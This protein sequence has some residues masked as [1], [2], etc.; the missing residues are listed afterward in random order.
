MI[1]NFTRPIRSSGKCA[2][3]TCKA[4]PSALIYNFSSS[5]TMSQGKVQYNGPNT[6]P[7]LFF[8]DDHMDSSIWNHLPLVDSDIFINSSIKSGTTWTQEIVLQLLYHGDYS[9]VGHAQM[10]VSLWAAGTLLTNP[11]KMELMEAQR[12]NPNVPR[13]VFKT[14]EPVEAIPF[15]AQNKY[16]FVSRDFRDIVWS[17]YRQ[18][19]NY[20]PQIIDKFNSF[21]SSPQ[22]NFDDGV[23]CLWICESL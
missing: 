8:D 15:R 10:D 23:Y 2:S 4:L 17:Y 20:H 13:R 12:L 9:A 18:H 5:V 14:H 16:L 21:R 1:Q 22:F 11:Q 3:Y 7:T 6:E 19:R